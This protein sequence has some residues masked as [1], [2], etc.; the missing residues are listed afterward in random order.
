MSKRTSWRC[1]NF[2]FFR[3]LVDSE[4]TEQKF[5]Q[6]L[7]E[8]L[9]CP[10]TVRLTVLTASQVDKLNLL[11]LRILTV[12]VDLK[13]TMSSAHWAPIDINAAMPRLCWRLNTPQFRPENLV[14]RPGDE[15]PKSTKLN[16]SR[17]VSGEIISMKWP[18]PLIYQQYACHIRA[19]NHF[20]FEATRSL[21]II[22]QISLMRLSTNLQG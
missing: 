8:H 3:W 7:Y 1:L 11:S 22:I 18:K 10:M 17:Y 6:T 2:G 13:D 14:H 15:H 12:A 9:D 4:K 21:I 19:I 16:I 5:C 20:F